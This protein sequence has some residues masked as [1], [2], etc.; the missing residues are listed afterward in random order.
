MSNDTSL[1][2]LDPNVDRGDPI[3][4]SLFYN[5]PGTMNSD[6]LVFA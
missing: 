3:G 2:S 4:E 5:L 1:P 6:L